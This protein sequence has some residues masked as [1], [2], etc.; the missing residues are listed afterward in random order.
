[1]TNWTWVLI[2]QSIQAVARGVRL[3][4]LPRCWEIWWVMVG[5]GGYWWRCCIEGE[6]SRLPVEETRLQ[7]L[8]MK[9]FFGLICCYRRAGSDCARKDAAAG[10]HTPGPAGA[11]IYWTNRGAWY[12]SSPVSPY[13]PRVSGDTDLVIWENDIEL[14][15]GRY[16][17]V[18]GSATPHDAALV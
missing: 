9:P 15:M 11:Q 5:N 6:K 3:G 8:M 17:D 18:D 12:G 2:A 1:M 4:V 13:C 10:V 14:S 16:S 7:T